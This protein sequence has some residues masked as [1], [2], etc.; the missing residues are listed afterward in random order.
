MNLILLDSDSS[1]QHLPAGDRRSIHIREVLLPSGK[2]RIFVG[3]PNGSMVV[4]A[5]ALQEDGSVLIAADWG[6]PLP[7]HPCPFPLTV[8]VGLSRPQTCRKILREAASLG[9][10]RLWFFGSEKG[11]PGYGSSKLWSTGEWRSLLLEGVE[12]SFDTHMPEIR[13]FENLEQ[14]CESIEDSP[15]LERIGLDPYEADEALG[16]EWSKGV[17]G[18]VCLAVGSERG[19]SATERVCLRDRGFVLKHLG[20]KILRTETAITLS[21]GVIAANRGW[22][23]SID[24]EYPV[25]D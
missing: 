19:W 11:E 22:W 4:G 13:R 16:R 2:S 9:L 23:Q 7:G 12:Q 17:A 21:A 18:Q 10:Q 6:Q 15:L 3:L 5:V 25:P 14:A 20:P 24:R 8:L 1:N